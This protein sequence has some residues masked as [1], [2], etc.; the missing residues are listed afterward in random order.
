MWICLTLDLSGSE[1]GP[2]S[3]S[4]EDSNEPLDSIAIIQQSFGRAHITHH[5]P[6]TGRHMWRISEMGKIQLRYYVCKYIPWLNSHRKHRKSLLYPKKKSA[7]DHTVHRKICRILWS[8]YLASN[9][10]RLNKLIRK[11]NIKNQNTFHPS[12]MFKSQP[13][14]MVMWRMTGQLFSGTSCYATTLVCLLS[15]YFSGI[16]DQTSSG[17]CRQT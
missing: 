1:K 5:T 8:L 12:T 4:C 13:T 7:N 2:A 6:Q 3:D 17:L 14:S 10:T 16:T 9:K 11:Q 15:G